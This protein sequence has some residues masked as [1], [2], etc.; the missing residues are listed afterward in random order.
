MVHLHWLDITVLA[1]YFV[2]VIGIGLL[3]RRRIKNLEDYYM[4]GRRF[5]KGLM[6][7]FAFGA[8]THADSAVALTA[9]TYKLGMA[10]IW[11]QW[12][13]LF[14]TPFY[15]LLS[16]IFGRARCLTTADLYELRYGPSLGILYAVWGVVINVGFL[17]VTLYGSAR[18]VEALT[19]GAIPSH[20]T[21]VGMTLAFL[22]YSLIGGLIATVWN[23]FLQGML[24]I[25]MSVLLIP[26]V[27]SAVG[28]VNG[29]R[30][31]LPHAD[32]LF[33]LV[34]PGE[35]GFYWI[36]VV[37]INQ[38]LG[39]VSQPHIM[40]NNAAGRTE[41]DNRIGFC[42]GMTL[43][44]LCSI[45]W[46][47]VGV[48]AIAYYNGNEIHPDHVFGAL[49]RDLLP[50][51]FAGLMIACILASVMDNG[52]V[53]V[54]TT[55]ALFTRNLMRIFKAKEN[56]QLELRV[57]RIFSIGYVCASIALA[58]SF[59]SVPS[60]VRFMWGLNPMIGIAFWL[61]LWWR[62]ANRYGAWA[63]FIAATT[64]WVLGV[65]KFG[66][67]GDAGLPYVITFYSLAGF[68]VGAVVSLLTKPEPKERLDR[69]FLTIN[70]PIGQEERLERFES[71]L[72]VLEGAAR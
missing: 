12:S 58:L 6:I 45:G 51:G 32:A 9:Q 50:V 38:L 20:W 15:W 23:E 65:H 57:S 56:P 25:V 11:Y 66:W 34:A 5:G 27:W 7:M 42:A 41:L 10:G 49:V 18:L 2:A 59:T 55:A 16:P 54:L 8:G 30:T 44:R 53:F 3:A 40:S 47:L 67:T 36:V 33:R 28:G 19:S 64:A 4:G 70:T 21:V 22:L 63:S 62:K 24:T 26:F 37:T 61:G 35:I 17:G 60:A 52:A 71:G 72:K 48:L 43:K 46:A 31:T 39:F 13:Q 68:G 14:N 69:F 29:I 1:G